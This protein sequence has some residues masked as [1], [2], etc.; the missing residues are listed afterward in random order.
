MKVDCAESSRSCILVQTLFCVQ[1]NHLHASFVGKTLLWDKWWSWQGSSN[2]A[3][4]TFWSQFSAK[5]A[6]VHLVRVGKLT[7]K[8]VKKSFFE[9][10]F[11]VYREKQCFCLVL[12]SIFNFD[13]KWGISPTRLS[14]MSHISV[15]I[16][17]FS[18]KYQNCAISSPSR[19]MESKWLQVP[20]TI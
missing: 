19:K 2:Q 18:K 15:N 11:V 13:K 4:T 17:E 3:K 6:I 10:K 1:R 8:N 20:K 9:P 5:T 12:S 7:T 14:K 16:F